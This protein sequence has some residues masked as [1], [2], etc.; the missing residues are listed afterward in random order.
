MEQDVG[1]DVTGT[2]VGEG[3]G[4]MAVLSYQAAVEVLVSLISVESLSPL[5]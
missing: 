2:G 3:E 5:L 4:V 1:D